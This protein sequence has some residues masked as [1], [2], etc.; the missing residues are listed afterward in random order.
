[1]SEK[2]RYRE[3]QAEPLQLD[4]EGI[5]RAR[6]RHIP[7]FVCR[8]L[9]R[10]VRQSQL[11]GLLRAAFPGAGSDFSRRI[12]AELDIH[13]Q[14]SGIE[15]IPASER[16][17]FASNHPLGGLDGIALIAL[18][19]QRYGDENIIFPVNDMLMHV[20]PLQTVFTP[21]NKYGRQGRER[22][23]GLQRAF[24]GNRHVIIFPAGLVSRRSKDGI[25]DLEWKKSF[26]TQAAATGRTIVPVR[27]EGCNRMRFYRFAHW[28]KRL[29]I[30]VNLEQVLLPS[31]LCAGRGRTFRITFLPPIDAAECLCSHPTAFDAAAALREKIYA[32]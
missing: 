21:V 23:G 29:R 1:M 31:E 16:L 25:R 11:N 3:S 27:F 10:I 18:L 6:A 7:G 12:L 5:L 24:S 14:V 13:I 4:V 15:N 30:P 9:A 2:L 22:V 26:L 32:E 20:R 19:G 28:R 8:L 17:V